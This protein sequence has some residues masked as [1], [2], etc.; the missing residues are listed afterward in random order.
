MDIIKDKKRKWLLDHGY[1]KFNNSKDI[2]HR[3]CN[4][5]SFDEFFINLNSNNYYFCPTSMLYNFNKDNIDHIQ[6]GL[7]E[8]KQEFEQMLRECK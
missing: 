8:V 3:R 7:K 4:K 6:Y 5:Y 2:F 1:E